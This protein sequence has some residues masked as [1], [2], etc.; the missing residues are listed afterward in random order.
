MTRKQIVEVHTS[1]LRGT[2]LRCV[3]HAFVLAT[4]CTTMTACI[5][6]SAPTTSVQLNG[7]AMYTT[8]PWADT[9]PVNITGRLNTVQGAVATMRSAQTSYYD[10]KITQANA[11]NERAFLR[12]EIARHDAELRRRLEQAE[13][14]R[15]KAEAEQSRPP[16]KGVKAK[17]VA[18]TVPTFSD[19][20]WEIG[21]SITS[22]A[23]SLRGWMAEGHPAYP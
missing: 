19:Y 9:K 22:H 5:S 8:Q 16:I 10:F 1:M 6:A 11:F 15:I 2:R 7:E 17:P 18:G 21:T 13:A 20:A 14:A 12:A 23:K 3:G 4:L